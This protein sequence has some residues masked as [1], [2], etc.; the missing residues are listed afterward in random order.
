VIASNV[1]VAG[2]TRLITGGRGWP[3][4]TS[5]RSSQV[6][7]GRRQPA[8]H[9]ASCREIGSSSGYADGR[10]TYSR[11]PAGKRDDRFR[12]ARDARVRWS[13]RYFLG[14]VVFGL[15]DGDGASVRYARDFL[16]S[17]LPST[18]TSDR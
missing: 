3:T 12:I 18:P 7:G 17:C 9:H 5:R 8:H 15:G 4:R 11:L 14:A 6:A 16:A 13:P 2:K 10:A 1:V